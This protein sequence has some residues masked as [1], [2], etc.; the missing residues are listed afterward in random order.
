[1]ATAANGSYLFTSMISPWVGG[2]RLSMAAVSA[3]NFG[4]CNGYGYAT[5]SFGMVLFAAG[6]H[7]Q[8][9]NRP[10]PG[11]LSRIF[12]LLF[13]L[14]MKCGGPPVGGSSS[15]SDDEESSDDDESS[16][17]GEEMTSVGAMF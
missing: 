5:V 8:S 1:M 15:K 12:F 9:K 7:N 16:S 6:V 11:P 17:S 13:W 14:N 4:P 10:P 2:G 3:G